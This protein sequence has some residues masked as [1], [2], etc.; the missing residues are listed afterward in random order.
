VLLVVGAEV[1][2]LAEVEGAAVVGVEAGTVEVAAP[3]TTGPPPWPS[4]G[5]EDAGD[6]SHPSPTPTPTLSN[7][8]AT[9][10]TTAMR[11]R[12]LPPPAAS[13][14]HPVPSP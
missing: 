14:A 3:A 7:I 11:R 13:F 12:L 10:A 6:R 2:V 5:L 4:A 1:E 9:S 8:A